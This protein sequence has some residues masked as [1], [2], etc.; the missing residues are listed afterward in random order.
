MWQVAW[1]HPKFGVILASCSYDR[2]VFV[3]KETAPNT[4]EIIYQY[5]GHELSGISH[6]HEQITTD[7][8]KSDNNWNGWN[9]ILNMDY[10]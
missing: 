7:R 2:K 8:V 6:R 1:A 5:S 10:S 9:C 3:W 4:W